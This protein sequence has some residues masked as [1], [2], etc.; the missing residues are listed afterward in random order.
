MDTPPEN[1]RTELR[2]VPYSAAGWNVV[3]YLLSIPIFLV[4]S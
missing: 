2:V 4:I 3:L 1:R